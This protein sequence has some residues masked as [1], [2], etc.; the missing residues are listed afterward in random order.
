MVGSGVGVGSGCVTGRG[1]GRGSACGRAIRE[2]KANSKVM[3][4]PPAGSCDHRS[5]DLS[6][7]TINGSCKIGGSSS[8]RSDMAKC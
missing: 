8:S 7:G 4:M 3:T 2:G 6:S 5:G 1:R